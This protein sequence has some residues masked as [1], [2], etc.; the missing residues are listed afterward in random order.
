MPAVS[1]AGLA[2]FALMQDEGPTFYWQLVIVA[3]RQRDNMALQCGP[4]S[5]RRWGCFLIVERCIFLAR[6]VLRPWSRG[7]RRWGCIPHCTPTTAT[8]RR[9]LACSR[10][11]STVTFTL[12]SLLFMPEAKEARAI[13]LGAGD[14]EGDLGQAII[15]LAAPGKAIRQHHHPLWPPIP[16]PDEHCA[17]TKLCS[18][19]VKVG[20]TGRHRRSR[21][22]RNRSIEHLRGC[23]IEV[24]KASRVK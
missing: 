2:G 21:F 14:S 10:H 5:S 18:F 23:V 9:R 13:P 19:L 3:R 22:L 17:G 24:A 15:G 4:S 1:A 7:L 6:K 20:E 12:S 8:G 16:F 11:R